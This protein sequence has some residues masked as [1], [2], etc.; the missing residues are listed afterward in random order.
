WHHVIS[1]IATARQ[2]AQWEPVPNTLQ[3]TV[4]SK[5][6]PV[7][8]SCSE[9]HSEVTTRIDQ[10]PRRRIESCVCVYSMGVILVT[11]V[12]VRGWRVGPLPLFC[13]LLSWTPL[14]FS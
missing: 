6:A 9:A 8:A 12:V 10:C 3:P 7:L 5:S 2:L 4:G 1:V 14:S 11:R 13:P